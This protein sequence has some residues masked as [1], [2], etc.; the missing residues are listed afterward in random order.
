MKTYPWGGCGRE[1]IVFVESGWECYPTHSAKN[2]EWMG[3]PSVGVERTKGKSK[4][5]RR[6]FD[7]FH[8]LRETRLRM[9]PHFYFI[10]LCSIDSYL[11]W[12]RFRSI[13]WRR[14]RAAAL[15]GANWR[16][17]LA[18]REAASYWPEARSMRARTR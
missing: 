12:V 6:F 16:A 1:D 2:A 11:G 17:K 7:S 10:Q 3:H 4:N 8:A 5:N 13:W 18:L 14:S 15:L 9:T